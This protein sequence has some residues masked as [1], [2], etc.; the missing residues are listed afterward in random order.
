[1]R[2]GFQVHAISGENGI[3]TSGKYQIGREAEV[4]GS[5]RRNFSELSILPNNTTN[6][7]DA[8]L[9]SGRRKAF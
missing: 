4:A 1:L 9:L 2:R 6:D 8:D 5:F 3:Q 7:W